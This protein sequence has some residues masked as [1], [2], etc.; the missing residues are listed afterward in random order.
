MS[1]NIPIRMEIEQ[2]IVR[3]VWDGKQVAVRV[4]QEI[5][6]DAEAWL[7]LLS[8]VDINAS[9]YEDKERLIRKTKR[10]LRAMNREGQKIEVDG[11]HTLGN[12]ALNEDEVE[13]FLKIAKEPGKDARGEDVRVIG[14]MVDSIGDF[15]ENVDIWKSQNKVSVKSKVEEKAL[16]SA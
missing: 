9:E 2:G 6:N 3:Q 15:R 10:A 11:F 7:G 16:V 12:L 8:L 1:L 14:A 13:F 5:Q 4:R